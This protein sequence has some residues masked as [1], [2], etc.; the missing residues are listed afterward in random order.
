M[1]SIET[2]EADEELVYDAG[3]LTETGMP[4]PKTNCS[5]SFAAQELEIYVTDEEKKSVDN[6]FEF[7]IRV[8][9]DS[10]M[11]E[12]TTTLTKSAIKNTLWTIPSS[13]GETPIDLPTPTSVSDVQLI[14]LVL[15]KVIDEG[16][17]YCDLK[18]F[19]GSSILVIK[20]IYELLPYSYE[21][22]ISPDQWVKRYVKMPNPHKMMQLFDEQEHNK[23]LLEMINPNILLNTRCCSDLFTY[24]H[25]LHIDETMRN[26]CSWSLGAPDV[27]GV[28]D[29]P[30]TQLSEQL[31]MVFNP[32][33]QIC[34]HKDGLFYVH[35]GLWHLSLHLIQKKVE[36]FDLSEPVTLAQFSRPVSYKLVSPY[37][38]YT[39]I[40]KSSSSTTYSAFCRFVAQ[41]N[42]LLME[43]VPCNGKVDNTGDICCVKV[44]HAMWCANESDEYF[45]EDNKS[46]HFKDVPMLKSN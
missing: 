26:I 17:Y 19:D 2:I 15:R 6:D 23:K 25:N 11:Y 8:T 44:T 1:T 37:F 33:R 40:F 43:I 20:F 12:H 21:L 36:Q 10:C 16:L 41:N 39:F 7:V 45:E 32:A 29:Y 9:V 3:E 28:V 14:A 13:L 46:Y 42:Q 24:N 38:V 27:C 31:S 5:T 18:S 30:K 4:E 35:D 34:F 22:L